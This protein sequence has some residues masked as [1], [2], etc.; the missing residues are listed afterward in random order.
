MKT[1][2]NETFG[3]RV[4]R[5]RTAADL[6]QEELAK[7]AE[8]P[9]GS[10]RNY[11]YDHRRPR[12]DAALRLA[13]AL[14]VTVEEL[15]VLPSS[16]PA[17]ADVQDPP[18]LRA[19]KRAWARAKEEERQQFLA[20][21]TEDRAGEEPKTQTADGRK[22]VRVATAKK[23]KPQAQVRSQSHSSKPTKRRKKS[24]SQPSPG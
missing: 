16:R 22:D 18:G 23:R 4:G 19:L 10:L 20:F 5:L 3:Q 11:E 17:R 6:T 14:G 21:V 1:S 24:R 2:P 9:V 15:L 8:L 7:K 13:R 12:A